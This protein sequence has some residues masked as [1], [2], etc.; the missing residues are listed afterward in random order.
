MK[1][2]TRAWIMFTLLLLLWGT[3]VASPFAY[4][5]KII[6][7]LADFLFRRDAFHIGL[8]AVLTYLFVGLILTM[9]LIIGRSRNRVYIAGFCALAGMVHHLIHCL[10][11]QQ[12]YAVSLAIAIGLALALLFLLIRPQGPALWLS[13][14]FIVSLPVFLILDGV[15]SPVFSFFDLSPQ[16]FEPFLQIPATSLT[17]RLAG[18]WGLPQIVWIVVPLAA[19]LIPMIMLTK[20][21]KKG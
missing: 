14:A 7:E 12:L 19:A 18:L 13:D 11:T 15:V 8:Q 2:Q 4:F 17:Q 20:G 6:A 21:R 5:A 10:R 1:S 3:I 16:M 9:L